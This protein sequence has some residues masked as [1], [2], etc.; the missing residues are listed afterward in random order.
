MAD[1]N[2]SHPLEDSKGGVRSPQMRKLARDGKTWT[3]TEQRLRDKLMKQFCHLE[4][5]AGATEAYR[6][7]WDAAF[8]GP[9]AKARAVAEFEAAKEE[10]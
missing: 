2:F 4:G 6:R 8:G 1:P 5:A 10:T 9:E 3:P 7:G